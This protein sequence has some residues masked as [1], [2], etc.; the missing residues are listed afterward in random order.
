MQA[1]NLIKSH[2]Y[3]A[4]MAVLFGAMITTT[5]PAFAQQDVD[6][7]YY[8]PWSPTAGTTSTTAQPAKAKTVIRKQQSAMRTASKKQVAKLRVK[9]TATRPTQ[10]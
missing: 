6:P 3:L 2:R 5:V 9:R 1:L 8:N 10:S 7:T 4:M